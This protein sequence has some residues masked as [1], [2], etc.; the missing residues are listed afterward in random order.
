MGASLCG[1]Y[2]GI[3]GYADDLCLI[4]RGRGSLQRM[5]DILSEYAIRVNITFS[6]NKNLEKSKTKCM[7]HFG[8]KHKHHLVS[9]KLNSNALPFTEK[10]KYLGTSISNV[11]EILCN[12]MNV[13]RGIYINK[14]YQLRQEFGWMGCEAMIKI[15]KVF[16]NSIYAANLYD[17]N[18]STYKKFATSYNAAIRNIWNLP[19]NTHRYWVEHTWILHLKQT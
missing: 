18:S 17:L 7:V 3:I 1:K 19:A 10:Y 16:N 4:A 6:T 12:D 13:K 15:Q 5:I 2:C 14:S 8:D 9:L 11:R